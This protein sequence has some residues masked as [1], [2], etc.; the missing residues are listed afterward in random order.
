MLDRVMIRRSYIISV[1]LVLIVQ[2]TVLAQSLSMSPYYS[3]HS[4]LSQTNLPSPNATDLGKFGDISLSHHTGK[5]N[6]SIPLYSIAQRDVTL[7]ISLNYDTSGLLMHQLPGWAGYGWTLSA[8]GCITRTVNYYADEIEDDRLPYSF[9]INY[10]N[11]YDMIPP[12]GEEESPAYSSPS[13]K[14]RDFMP[15]MFHFNFMGKTGCFLLGNDGNWKVYSESNLTV[16]FDI[17]DSNNYGDPFYK[18]YYCDTD[19]PMPKTIKGFTLIDDDGTR[20]EFGGTTD[21]IEYSTD[22]FHLSHGDTY[23]PW[24]ATSWY[25]RKV[26]DRFGK[27]LFQFNYSRNYFLAQLGYVE[28]SEYYGNSFEHN[29]GY[30]DAFSGTLNAPVYLSNI[31]MENGTR[32]SFVFSNPFSDSQLSKIIYPSFYNSSSGLPNG[33]LQYAYRFLRGEDMDWTS[34]VFLQNTSAPEINECQAP[35]NS[36]RQTDPLSSI[37][38]RVL[39][40]V[41]VRSTEGGSIGKSYKMHYSQ[42]GRIHLSRVEIDSDSNS[43]E[44]FYILDYQDY[45]KVPSDCLTSR[46]DNWGYYKRLNIVP[47]DTFMSYIPSTLNGIDVPES[48]SVRMGKPRPQTLDSLRSCDLLSTQY[49]MLTSIVYPTGGC[50]RIEYEQNDFSKCISDDRQS[51]LSVSGYTGGLRVKSIGEYESVTSS[52]PLKKRTYTYKNPDNQT[53]SGTLF[54]RPQ[55][56]YMWKTKDYYGGTVRIASFK[57]TPVRPL[58][59]HFGPHVGYSYIT[60]TNLDGSRTIYH[61]SN[62]QDYTDGQFVYSKMQEG[63]SPFDLF[64]ERGYKRGRLIHCATFD[65]NGEVMTSVTNTYRTDGLEDNYV[66]ASNMILHPDGLYYGSTYYTGGTYKIFYPKYRRSRQTLWGRQCR[67]QPKTS[68]QT[69]HDCIKFTTFAL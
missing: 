29:S 48:L 52:T 33:T 3:L 38:L 14:N 43:Y 69:I 62:L 5:A 1:I 32:I 35:T 27:T 30:G 7:D 67:C 39:T 50:T 41:T 17:S 21:A 45:D 44:G 49:G 54:S 37:G 66:Y 13:G 60:E 16:A 28:Y 56:Y 15:D 57:S 31:T 19:E 64:C 9:L 23:T 40:G 34:F 51:V 20:Y 12:P 10:F 46:I 58:S 4:R 36:N 59:N 8:G 26:S 6:I 25:L 24:V 53:S 61:Y 2:N 68:C 47:E 42:S 11:A 55:Y 22:L 65:S 18:N 63:T